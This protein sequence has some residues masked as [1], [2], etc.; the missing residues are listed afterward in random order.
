MWKKRGAYR[1]LV[2]K[3]DRQNFE[4]LGVDERIFLKWLLRKEHWMA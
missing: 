4:D 1:P 3:P 2:G